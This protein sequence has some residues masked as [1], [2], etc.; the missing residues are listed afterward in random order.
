LALGARLALFGI[1]ALVLVAVLPATLALLLAWRRHHYAALVL[2]DRL[3]HPRRGGTERGDR[4]SNHPGRCT[5]LGRS[6]TT[7]TA[8]RAEARRHRRPLLR[9]PAVSIVINWAPAATSSA[10]ENFDFAQPPGQS[11]SALA[12]QPRDFFF[13]K[14]T[15]FVH[16]SRLRSWQSTIP[17]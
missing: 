9:P 17:V 10:T 5:V 15:E 11:V 2:P 7:V 4:A 6:T 13:E 3:R 12:P 16:L 8:A 1:A 14:S